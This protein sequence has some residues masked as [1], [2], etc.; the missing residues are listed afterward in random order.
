MPHQDSRPPVAEVLRTRAMRCVLTIFLVLTACGNGDKGVDP[1]A[2][3]AS[4]CVP[5]T[6]LAC[7]DALLL[8]LDLQ[9]T[10][11]PGLI[12]NEADG[13]GWKSLVDATA[14]GYPPSEGYIYAQFT[15]GGLVKQTMSDEQALASGDWDIAFRRTYIRLNSG[16]SGPSCVGSV[17]LPLGSDFD[18]L[19]AVPEGAVFDVEDFLTDACDI[20]PD[21]HQLGDPAFALATYYSYVSCVAMT[22]AVYVLALPDGRNIKVTVTRYYSEAN[23]ASCNSAGTTGSPSG[24]GNVQVRWAYLP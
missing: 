23:Q 16:E 4:R 9:S 8:G 10:P 20:I 13:G 11:A 7:E 24:S 17:Q 18:A 22:D 5:A 2:D 12:V 6:S 21:D 1:P 3:T 14:G 19:T 15:D